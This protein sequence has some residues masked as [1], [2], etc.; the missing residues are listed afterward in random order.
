MRARPRNTESITL[1]SQ[2]TGHDHDLT[3]EYEVEVDQST[4]DMPAYFEVSINEAWYRKR[5]IVNMLS[6]KGLE[7]IKEYI[8]LKRY[9]L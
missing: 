5:N 6:S 4:Q 1:F 9:A 8:T 2:I 7:S 3:I